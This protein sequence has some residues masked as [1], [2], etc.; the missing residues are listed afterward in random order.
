MWR[1]C[2]SCRGG[3][4]SRRPEPPGS[5]AIDSVENRVGNIIW[6]PDPVYRTADLARLG[7]SDPTLGAA[8]AIAWSVVLAIV[9]FRY[10]SGATSRERFYL[11]LS[12][13]S[14]WLAYSLL[15]LS[16]ATES[17]IEIAV[18]VC[19]WGCSPPVPGLASDCCG[20]EVTRQRRKR[21][22]EA[23]TRAVRRRRGFQLPPDRDATPTPNGR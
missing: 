9:A 17:P 22:R 1:I 7:F 18:V 5:F 4:A 8:L 21:L 12:M 11:T 14:F 13:G 19:R 23:R 2:P 16:T 6:V 20:F 10:R 15:R 3:V